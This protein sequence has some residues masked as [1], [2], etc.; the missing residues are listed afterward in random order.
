[1]RFRR[2]FPNQVGKWPGHFRDLV[3]LYGER[4]ED[5]AGPPEVAL[6][7][8][9]GIAII[10]G[11]E[12]RLDGREFPFLCFLFERARQAEPALP[13]HPAADEPFRAFLVEWARRHPE[14]DLSK[15]GGADWRKNFD[16]E[17]L[18]KPLNCLRQKLKPAGLANLEPYLFPSRGPL[19]LRIKTAG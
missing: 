11:V 8:T 1:M 16:I 9:R 3:R 2:I 14:F 17:D 19:G 4:V 10:N 6:D 5:L 18:K 12:M 15:G 7:E 13:N